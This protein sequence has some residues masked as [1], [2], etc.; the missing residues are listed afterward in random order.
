M[1]G[2][3]PAKFQPRDERA[4]PVVMDAINKG[5]A[6]QGSI[7]GRDSEPYTIPGFPD[8]NTANAAR[9]SVYC[10]AKHLGVSCSSRT[11]EDIIEQEDGTFL[12]RFWVMSRA[13]AKKRVIEA[14]GGDPTKLAY[15]P[16]RKRSRRVMDDEGNRIEP[17]GPGIPT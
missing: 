2:K 17:Y 3:H 1:T 9:R 11:N 12:L 5:Y 16:F 14:T 13:S 15:N 4:H 8:F 6:E 10:A 7:H